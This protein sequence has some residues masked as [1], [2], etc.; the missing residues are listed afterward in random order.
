M[1]GESHDLIAVDV[2]SPFGVGFYSLRV[3]SNC[4]SSR[5]LCPPGPQLVC[6][7][8]LKQIGTPRDVSP[9]THPGHLAF[10]RGNIKDF[11]YCLLRAVWKSESTVIRHV[12]TNLVLSC[13]HGQKRFYIFL[14]HEL[15][16][17]KHLA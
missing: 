10:L 15:I 11:I 2:F 7:A 12:F 16:K 1:E 9:A 5:V 3:I 13:V 8:V 14:L 6:F 17:E 4:S